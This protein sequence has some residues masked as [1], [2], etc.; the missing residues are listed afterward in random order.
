MAAKL[1][2][3]A[4]SRPQRLHIN[5]GSSDQAWQDNGSHLSPS[6]IWSGY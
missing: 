2:W 6:V 3:P 5:V 1:R 4:A